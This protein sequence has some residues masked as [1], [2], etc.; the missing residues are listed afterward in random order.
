M[1]PDDIITVLSLF[2]SASVNTNLPFVWLFSQ[3]TDSFGLENV[4]DGD[5]GEKQLLIIRCCQ[6]DY[7]DQSAVQSPKMLSLI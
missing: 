3:L 1:L 5:R 4:Q 6:N 7:F 2:N